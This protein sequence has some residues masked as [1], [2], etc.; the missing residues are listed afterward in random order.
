MGQFAFVYRE[1]AAVQNSSKA[2]NERY[3]ET[4]TD[5]ARQNGWFE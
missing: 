3:L 4:L 5:Y 2:A 1:M